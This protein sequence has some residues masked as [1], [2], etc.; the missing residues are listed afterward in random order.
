[1]ASKYN[2]WVKMARAAKTP[3]EI[4]TVMESIEEAM[5]GNKNRSMT[6]DMNEALDIL[7]GMEGASKSYGDEVPL[8]WLTEEEQFER[9]V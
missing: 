1:M 3:A 5:R 4:K 9:S 2:K 6:S 8:E 7:V